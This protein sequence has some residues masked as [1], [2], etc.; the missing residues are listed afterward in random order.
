MTLV[1]VALFSALLCLVALRVPALGL[2]L[3][4]GADLVLM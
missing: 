1:I 3:A 4:A 2:G